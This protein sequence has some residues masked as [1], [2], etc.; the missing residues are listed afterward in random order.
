[1]IDLHAHTNKS[2]GTLSPTQLVEL[3]CKK[4]LTAL[5]V[6]DHDTIAGVAEALEAA[7]T[8]R[9]SGK[10]ETVPE[11]I[12]GIEFS[13]EWNGGDVHVVG[14]NLDLESEGFQKELPGFLDSREGRN[15][16]MAKRL[17]EAGIGI[18]YE[19]LEKMFPDRVLTRAHFATYLLEYGYVKSTK[20]AFDR[21]LSPGCPCY[22][23]REKVTPTAAVKMT[24]AAGGIPVLAHPMIYHLP[25]EDIRAL[26]TEMKEAGLVGIEAIYCT[27]SE[28]DEAFVR[29]LAKEYDLKISGG[30][31]FHGDTKPGLDLGTGYG[32]LCVPDEVWQD[33]KNS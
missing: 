8:L 18:C 3:G 19:G 7:K 9:A 1:M 24:L 28:E 27:Y 22:V 15:R 20:E 17:K 11:V 33:L 4:G 13:T 30:S 26:V 6:T 2:D 12:P 21:Y 14:L 31:D 10:Y 23:P 16:E 25:E 32:S 29:K 5:A